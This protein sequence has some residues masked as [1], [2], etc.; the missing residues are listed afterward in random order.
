MND[1]MKFIDD[2]QFNILKNNNSIDKEDLSN[3][4]NIKQIN[5]KFDNSSLFLSKNC[6]KDINY[7]YDDFDNY[8]NNNIIISYYYSTAKFLKYSNDNK[9]Y[10][11]KMI[12]SKNY[13]PK[14]NN[15]Y[16]NNY[17]DNKYNEE[18]INN[19]GQIKN[20]IYELNNNNFYQYEQQLN[21]IKEYNNLITSPGLLWDNNKVNAN[22]NSNKY[23]NLVK[24]KEENIKND[25]LEKLNSKSQNH[26]INNINCPPFIPTNYKIQQGK[27]ISR[28]SSNDSFSKDRESDSTSAISEKR[29]EEN[30]FE[31]L[32]NFNKR[33][34][35]E[36]YEQ[37][38]G[39]GE[40]LV[41]MFGRK[42]W[43]CK[44]CNNFNYE[45]RNKCNR[46]GIMKKPKKITDLKPKKEQR[47][48]NDVKER[49]NK[50]GDWICINCRNLNYSFRNF[51]N[52]CKIPKI[53]PILKVSNAL[54]SK[55]VDNL[56]KYQIYSFSPSMFFFN[57]VP[58]RQFEKIETK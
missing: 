45:T 33:K 36:L 46:C 4:D 13:I 20:C 21:Y 3:F 40:Y 57:N 25:Y 2:S 1:K 51:C 42:G 52:R 30:N 28:K 35:S 15:L 14:N 17:K 34:N 49:N 29:E 48:I 37:N 22:I 18:Y 19:F 56:Q 12:N 26:I 8:R 44:L 5:S 31:N 11:L 39:K 43:I 32:N 53:D 50:K 58:F 16:R 41:E 55:E 10:L 38:L 54:D 7:D 9:D 6:E 47:V 27:D 24:G 23:N